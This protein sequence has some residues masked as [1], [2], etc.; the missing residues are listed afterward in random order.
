MRCFTEELP[1][2]QSCREE[3][4]IPDDRDKHRWHIHHAILHLNFNARRME[5][6]LA[7]VDE[8]KVEP[9]KVFLSSLHKHE[10]C[11]W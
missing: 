3:R 10:V 6:Y 1:A 8:G 2:S 7:M 11:Q 9:A 4:E 5:R